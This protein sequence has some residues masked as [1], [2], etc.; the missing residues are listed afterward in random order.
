MVE[1]KKME[2]NFKKETV[3]FVRNFTFQAYRPSKWKGGKEYDYQSQV[4]HLLDRYYTIRN[5]SIYVKLVSSRHPRRH[6]VR[7]TRSTIGL[8]PTNS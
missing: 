2:V 6:A 3:V 1:S 5:R 8:R 4:F 7:F